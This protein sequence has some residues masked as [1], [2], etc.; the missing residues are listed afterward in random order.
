MEKTSTNKTQAG[1]KYLLAYKITIPIF[2]L[3]MEFC[4]KYVSTYSRTK[5]QMEQAVRS[6]KQNV[7]EGYSQKSLA[8]YI[9]LVGV[10]R[11]S[12]EELLED[13]K[14][15][16][17]TNKILIW[18]KERAKREIGEI[19]E[20]WKIIKNNPTLPDNPYFPH[21]P[22][23][24]EKAVNLMVTL[25]TQATYLM[26]KLIESLEEKH[27][28]EGGYSENLLKKRLEFRNRP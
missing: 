5:D 25:T 14:D 27:R 6:G 3:T 28:T 23:S 24:P 17:R 8:S 1:Y 26:D 2:D 16:A 7:L 18:P 4:K 13:Y 22:Y 20:I 19:G 21:L 9:K 12:L 15:F 10:A 11:G